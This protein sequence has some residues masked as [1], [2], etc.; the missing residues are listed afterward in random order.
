MP[1]YNITASEKD[2]P[3]VMDTPVMIPIFAFVMDL[4]MYKLES[5][6]VSIRLRVKASRLSVVIPRYLN[7]L[8]ISR[9]C[10]FYLCYYVV[11]S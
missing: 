8:P 6:F 1:T 3:G 9:Y 4:I 5:T 2:I 11:V 10:S 7:M